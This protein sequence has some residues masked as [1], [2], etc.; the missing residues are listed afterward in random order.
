MS[1]ATI[2]EMAKFV[3]D[4]IGFLEAH[5]VQY[6]VRLA[7]STDPLMLDLFYICVLDETGATHKL[8]ISSE[9]ARERLGY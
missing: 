2:M 5:N 6:T 7:S 4:P 8:K 3:E 9:Y 1:T